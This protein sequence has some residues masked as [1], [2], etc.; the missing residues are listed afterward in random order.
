VRRAALVLAAAAFGSGCGYISFQKPLTNDEVRLEAEVREYYDEVAQSFATGNADAL[1]SLFLSS[2]THPMTQDQIRDW[3]RKFFADNGAAHFKLRKI[4]F[5]ELSYIRAAVTISYVV[6]TKGARGDFGGVEHDE[7][8]R[9]QGRWF[10][11]SWDKVQ[12]AKP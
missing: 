11:A 5:E 9:H 3:G 1:A 4:E 10:V 8:V 7:L 6:E 12:S 2:I